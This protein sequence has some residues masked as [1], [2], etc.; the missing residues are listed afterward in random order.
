[1][2]THQK[3]MRFDASTCPPRG[4]IVGLFVGLSLDR[5]RMGYV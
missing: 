2:E 5:H 3:V 4:N 1:M